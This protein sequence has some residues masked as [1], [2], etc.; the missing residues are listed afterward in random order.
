[1]GKYDVAMYEYMEDEE[2]FADLVNVVLYD[3]NQVVLPRMLKPAGERIGKRYRDLK[4]QLKNGDWLA[5]VAV[6]NQESIDY[7]MPFRMMEYDCLEY[8]RQLQQIKRKRRRDIEA[9][10][11]KVDEWSLRL[12]KEDKLNPI[13]SI[14]LYHGMDEWNGPKSLKDMMNFE[15]ALP[16]WEETFHNYGMTI[17]CVNELDDFSKFRT[18]LR[19][20]LEVIP[21]RG[22]KKKLRELFAREEYKHL[23][24][25]T[26]EVIAVFTDNKKMLEVLE[27]EE[28]EEYDM[29]KALDDLI[30]DGRE[31]GRTEGKAEGKAETLLE[32]IHNLMSSMS[33]TAEQAMAALLVPLEERGDYLAKL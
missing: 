18:E 30:A 16:G 11:D 8:R 31:E 23:D 33:W 3:G 19:Q 21:C 2:R 13:H 14:C 27:E 4:K 29:C 26:A 24:R 1:M 28:K 32:A 10:G 20:F 6:E 15:G 7:S 17:L 25:E 5:L 22:D 12:R 9:T